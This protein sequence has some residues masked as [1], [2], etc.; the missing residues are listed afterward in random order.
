MI[1]KIVLFLISYAPLFLIYAINILPD[2]EI[3]QIS[4]I[5]NIHLFIPKMSTELINLMLLVLLVVIPTLC[6]LLYV[7]KEEKKGKFKLEET[8]KL[9]LTQDTIISYLM[10]YILP[11]LTDS[12]LNVQNVILFCIIL[13]LAVRLDVIY[14]NPTLILLKYN[15]YK[16]V[17]EDKYYITKNSL[18]DIEV[19]RKSQEKIKLIPLAKNIYYVGEII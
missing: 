11:F 9:E 2:I 15:I 16:S 13:I 14:I 17:N 1:I 6:F 3:K 10:T 19:A 18:S 8:Q 7:N 12:K 5:A 4:I